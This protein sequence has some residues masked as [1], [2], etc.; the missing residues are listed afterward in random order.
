ME[1]TLKNKDWKEFYIKDLFLIERGKR[2]TIANRIK[3]LFP[4]VTAGYKN[5]GVANFIKNQEQKTYKQS[6]TIDMF[7]NV[8]YRNYNFK[9]DDNI[10]VLKSNI[11][12]SDNG[13]FISVAIQKS[14]MNIFSYG[15]Q[16]RLKTIE[17]QKILLPITPK[18]EP[19]YVFMESYIRKKE[20]ENLKIYKNYISKR[21]NELEK[22]GNIVSLGEKNWDE[23]FLSQG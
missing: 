9:C 23:F 20:Q 16:F 4:L 12:N 2:L 17:K 19:D 8:F 6:I 22:I 13:I 14:T 3:G 5:E 21:I 15:K 10:H 11:L 1:M 7:G 18:G